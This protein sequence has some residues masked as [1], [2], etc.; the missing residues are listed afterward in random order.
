MIRTIAIL[1][2]L[3]A[4]AAHAQLTTTV[5]RIRLE[6]A[7]A[8]ELEATTLDLGHAVFNEEN[9]ADLR[10][11]DGAT[12]GGIRVGSD[13]WTNNMLS[14]WGGLS[15][16]EI[17]A[18]VALSI[19]HV[20]LTP[21]AFSADLLD[22][23]RLSDYAA[24]TNAIWGSLASKAAASNLVAEAARLDGRIDGI[25][26]AGLGALTVESDPIASSNLAVQAGILSDLGT[27]TTGEV[28]RL[29]GRI[30]GISAASLGAL[31]EEA[32]PVWAA[33]SNDVARL[34]DVEALV[35]LS[36][37][38]FQEQ[39]AAALSA[40]AAVSGRVDTV[41][42]WGDHSEAG[43]L[44]TEADAAAL[45]A[46][47]AVSGRVDTVEGW[48]DHSAAGYLTTEADAAALS[49]VAAVSGRVDTVEGWGDHSEAGYATTNAAGQIA[50]NV[51]S[52]WSRWAATN[53][54]AWS[55]SVHEWVDMRLR[56]GSDNGGLAF[57]E[58]ANNTFQTLRLSAEGEFWRLQIGDGRD[59]AFTGPSV[60]LWARSRESA[61]N[62]ENLARTNELFSMWM[63]GIFG[64]GIV[65][66]NGTLTIESNLVVGTGHITDSAISNWDAAYGWGDHG[67]AGYLTSF[68]TNNIDANDVEIHNLN[69]L[70]VGL[71]T[72][73]GSAG[74]NISPYDGRFGGA[75]DFATD[76]LTV[77]GSRVIRHSTLTPCRFFAPGGGLTFDHGATL[78]HTLSVTNDLVTHTNWHGHTRMVITTTNGYQRSSGYVEVFGGTNLLDSYN[79]GCDGSAY[80]SDYPWV[81]GGMTITLALNELPDAPGVT[82][83][84]P[85]I[86]SLEVYNMADTGLV[87]RAMIDTQNQIIGGDTPT[88]DRQWANKAYVDDTADAAFDLAV[89]EV[90]ERT[91]DTDLNGYIMRWNPRFDTVTET[92]QIKWKYGGET[93]WSVDGEGATV[94]PEIRSFTVGGGATA[95]LTVWSYSGGAT[96]LIP[97]V[98][99][100]LHTWTRLDT[101]AIVSAEMVDDFTAQVVFTNAAATAMFVRLVDVSGGEGRPVIYANAPVHFAAGSIYHATA[102][103]SYIR[104]DGGTNTIYFDAASN[105]VI[106]VDG[107]PA[108]TISPAG[109]VGVGT[110]PSASFSL[111]TDASFYAGGQVRAGS[112]LMSGNGQVF[113]NSS[114]T[115]WLQL[116]GTNIQFRSTNGVTG[117]IQMIYE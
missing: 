111:R 38:Y 11:G 89:G 99:T 59:S 104:P 13:W 95:T 97:E 19:P 50:T 57:Y 103:N 25:S 87:S 41:E 14:A 35:A 29:D 107:S 110:T 80:T 84:P 61:Y 6:H 85:V 33:A 68:W 18:L 15:R 92:N 44:T 45:S 82:S 88:A 69:S 30:D 4:T 102:T 113:L 114:G 28:A 81:E 39:D 36:L 109:D 31:T 83:A 5:K 40:V 106:A 27:L 71:I 8:A 20:D 112:Y 55:N 74:R 96:N 48:G 52:D 101:N 76:E 116:D 63:G 46:V 16:I 56:G 90:W 72:G 64:D 98:S 51:A 115:S 1:V 79:P 34:R 60:P 62:N 93:Y 47:A 17:E 75:W 42:G 65:S 66:S 73:S 53:D 32:D 100:N 21:Y 58:G 117:R 26:A 2:L 78:P 86:T 24:A 3:A 43:Y 108:L 54:I 67:E 22:Y 23:A 7:T 77:K 91:D 9:L 70:S 12:P 49:A 37:G 10:I 94:I 105:M